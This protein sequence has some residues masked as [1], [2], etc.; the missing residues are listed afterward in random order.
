MA[1]TQQLF[2]PR[3]RVLIDLLLISNSL[4]FAV[5][6]MQIVPDRLLFSFAAGWNFFLIGIFY[7]I[8]RPLLYVEIRDGAVVGPSLLF[9]RDSILIRK[10]DVRRS[11]EFHH[12]SDF[13]GYRD[14]WSVDGRRVRLYRRFLGKRN[15][16]KIIMAIK[17]HPFRESAQPAKPS[18]SDGHPPETNG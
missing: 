11:L 18:P 14:L 3:T 10:I 17:D 6:A 15:Q 4:L 16:Y 5:L 12:K 8:I 13:W 9:K 7:G 2:R 1:D